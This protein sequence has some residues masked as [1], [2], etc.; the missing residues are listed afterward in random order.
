MTLGTRIVLALIPIIILMIAWWVFKLFI[1]ITLW[2]L[3]I[4]IVLSI[5]IYLY[6]HFKHT[7]R[8]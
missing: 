6:L 3:A 4:A 1:K 8:A 5:V 7:G 2:L